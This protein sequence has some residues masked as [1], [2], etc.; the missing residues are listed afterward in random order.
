MIPENVITELIDN[1][2]SSEHSEL[3]E[4][5]RLNAEVELRFFRKYPFYKLA[6]FLENFTLLYLSHN[7]MIEIGLPFN[8][9]ISSLKLCIDPDK[10]PITTSKKYRR[11]THQSRHYPATNIGS[12][13]SYF[14]DADPEKLPHN[15]Y[16]YYN[17]FIEQFCGLPNGTF[18]CGLVEGDYGVKLGKKAPLGEFLEMIVEREIHMFIHTLDLGERRED[19]RAYVINGF[20]I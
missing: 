1:F 8:E 17:K 13:S 2:N 16:K 14:Y 3:P 19:K 4:S 9:V 11:Y 15:N 5:W 12:D 10:I 6:Y 18:K 7:G 20:D